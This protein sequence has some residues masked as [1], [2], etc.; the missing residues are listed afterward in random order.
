MSEKGF[1]LIEMAIVI[2][3]I[4]VMITGAIRGAEMIKQA[5][6]KKVLTDATALVDAQNRYMERQKRYA[7]DADNDGK[8]D[9]T[10][11]NT[12]ANNS[13]GT[14]STDADFAFE[15]LKTLGIMPATLSNVA[16]AATDEGGYMYYAGNAGTSGNITVLNLVVI[17]NVACRAAFVMETQI[18]KEQP[19]ATSSAATGKIRQI[20]SGSLRTSGTWTSSGSSCVSG[21]VVNED[22]RTDIAF[23]FNL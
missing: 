9:C 6:A 20:V 23:I 11:L 7:G 22:L 8:I 4:G 12:S 15:E 21:S 1:T 13:G 18:D 3:I 10:T 16:I 19:D 17:R 14:T 5:K 2:V